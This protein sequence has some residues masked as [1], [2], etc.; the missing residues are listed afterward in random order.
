MS[1]NHLNIYLGKALKEHWENYCERRQL[2]PGAAIRQAIQAQLDK[3]SSENQKT[4]GYTQAFDEAIEGKKR[5]ELRFT[6]SE[7][8]AIERF[9]ERDDCSFNRWVINLIRSN[10]TKQP[11]FGMKEIEALWQSNY[12]LLAIGR[13]LNQLMHRLNQ[14]QSGSMTGKQIDEL[15]TQIQQHT[16]QVSELIAANIDRWKLV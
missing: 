1:N 3:E 12:Q 15:I 5:K 7:I 2:K 4:P 10:L 8:A 11:Q 9:A 14:G 16:R 6:A 13:N